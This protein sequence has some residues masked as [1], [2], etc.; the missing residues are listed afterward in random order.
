MKV[1]VDVDSENIEAF[2]GICKE[3]IKTPSEIFNSF[4]KALYD[5]WSSSSG[6]VWFGDATFDQVLDCILNNL[7]V[8][9]KIIEDTTK[10]FLI[11]N[12]LK[13]NIDQLE[14]DFENKSFWYDLKNYENEYD[15]LFMKVNIGDG[16]I[17]ISRITGVP[18][19]AVAVLDLHKR[20]IDASD[21]ANEFINSKRVGEYLQATNRLVKLKIISADMT[22]CFVSITL[23]VTAANKKY[24]P[25]LDTLNL[26]LREIANIVW[27]NLQIL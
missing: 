13:S 27:R 19:P 14:V 17:S 21:L 26:L 7:N 4:I 2:E 15:P 9:P 18:V 8:G 12:H 20:I 1:E 6:R 3:S 24:F 25:T 11:K 22:P 10:G 16:R 5:A 23:T